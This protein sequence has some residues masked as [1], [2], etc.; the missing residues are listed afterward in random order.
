MNIFQNLLIGDAL[1]K[2]LRLGFLIIVGIPAFYML[3]NFIRRSTTKRFSAQFGLITSK[4]VLYVGLIIIIISVLSV[5]GLDL[6]HLF[7]AAG[8][9]GIAIG[10]ASQT[11]M[12]NVISGLF[13]IGEQPFVVGDVITVEGVTGEV[14]SIDMLSIKLREFDNKFVRIP[15]ETI[16]KSAVTNLTH[17]PIRRVNLN[18]GIAYKEN[19]ARVR[20]ILFES[21]R[22]NPLCLQEPE[23]V[24]IFSNFGSSSIDL[25]FGVWAE[26]EDYLAVKNSMQ[27][28]IKAR[29][30]QEGIEIPFPHLSL[31]SGSATNPLPVQMIESQ[32]AK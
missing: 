18:I 13:L 9:L 30:D 31:Y 19:I 28:Q 1:E 22:A 14:L 21:A 6:T 23:P 25:M 16:V 32:S 12:S 29:F 2:M 27:E 17:F 20:E 3:S 7:A 24:F 5:F 11:S 15:N 8:I 4:I 10:F 26:K